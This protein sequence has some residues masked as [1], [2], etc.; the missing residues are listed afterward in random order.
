M[1]FDGTYVDDRH[2]MAVTDAICRGGTIM[3]LNRH[4]INRTDTSPLMRCSFEETTD[5]LCDA[6]AFAEAEN[7]R[8]VAS[9]I[10]QLASRD[11][12]VQVCMPCHGAV[13]VQA[14]TATGSIRVLHSTCRS[15]R[16]TTLRNR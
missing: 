15:H 16:M 2:L 12:V 7:A 8:S 6:A 1:S 10:G 3:P 13:A 11:G 14:A 5:V 9:L 4:G